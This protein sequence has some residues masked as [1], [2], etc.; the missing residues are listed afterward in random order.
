MNSVSNKKKVNFMLNRE[1]NSSLLVTQNFINS[2]EC[3]RLWDQV[4]LNTCIKLDFD[5]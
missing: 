5:E 4:T 1:Q 2:S 3:L